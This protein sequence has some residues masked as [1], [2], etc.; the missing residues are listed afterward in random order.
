MATTSATARRD[1]ELSA[2]LRDRGQRVTSQRILIHRALGELDRHVSAD[3]VLVAVRDRLPN[4][5]L[6]TVYATLELFRELGLVR[7]LSVA[8]SPVLYDPRAEEHQ[9]FVCRRC[10]RVTDLEARVDAASA[11]DA[12]R[13]AGMVPEE[14]GVV[15]AGL[16][17]RCA[18][19]TA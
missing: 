18:S 1:A 2:R 8:G 4:V 10:G 6:P 5:S 11:I 13:S 17:A 12:A 9:H 19:N 16:C 14:A 3:D 7:R 15:V